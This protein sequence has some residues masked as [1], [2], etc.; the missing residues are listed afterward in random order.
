MERM[1]LFDVPDKMIMDPVHG[2]IHLFNE[3]VKVIDHPLFQRLKYILQNDVVFMVFPGCSH[4]RFS[5]SLGTMHIAGRYFRK[6]TIEYL[7]KSSITELSSLQSKAIRYVYKCIRLAA[8][9]H[10]TG[11]SPFSHQFETVE[12]IQELYK[13]ENFVHSIFSA[14]NTEAI[15]GKMP[16]V[17]KHEHFSVRSAYHIL[18]SI[19]NDEI[20]TEDVLYFME[21]TQISPSDNLNLYGDTLIG[22]FL[23]KDW[24]NFVDAKTITAERAIK[25]FYTLLK[26]IISGELDADK[27]DYILR[28]SYFSGCNYGKYNIDHLINNLRVGYDFI[29]NEKQ[30]INIKLSIA[31]TEKGLGAL[32]DFIYARFQLYHEVYNHKSVSGFRKLLSLSIKEVVERDGEIIKKY[33][34]SIDYFQF[35]TDCFFWEKF[36]EESQRNEKSFCNRILARK[37]LSYIKKI[38]NSKDEEVRFAC[39]KMNAKSD[40]G[41]VVYWKSSIKFSSINSFYND[42]IVL[43]K[44]LTGKMQLQKISDVTDFFEKFNREEIYH[45]F[46]ID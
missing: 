40:N 28:D 36:R 45:L 41:E 39:Q 17:I 14:I 25:D 16:Q 1:F 19:E 20:A 34:S 9:L 44:D 3:E 33:L 31:I 21:G 10:D 11:H 37:K 46:K 15:F 24:Q 32:E 27:M 26:N 8:L 35:F 42:I 22:I 13:D 29:R 12:A 30:I 2:A 4:N 6:L 43:T 23:G 18:D 38:E 5:H 7:K